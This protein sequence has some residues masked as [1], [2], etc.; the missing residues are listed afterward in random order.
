MTQWTK[1][2]R[3]TAPRVPPAE[4]F[5]ATHARVRAARAYIF[6]IMPGVLALVTLL[7]VAQ[8]LINPDDVPGGVWIA[9]GAFWF[10]QLVWIALVK[11]GVSAMLVAGLSF[12]ADGLIEFGAMFSSAEPV[13]ASASLTFFIV[14]SS[15][16]LPAWATVAYATTCAVGISLA[17]PNIERWGEAYAIPSTAF[18]ALITGALCAFVMS[19]VRMTEQRLERVAAEQVA[20]RERLE[21][22]DRARDR[23]IANVSHEL[24]T[25]LTSTIGSIETLMRE[26]LEID[27]G[28]R[29]QLM[30]VARDGGHRLLACPRRPNDWARSLAMQSSGST[31]AWDAR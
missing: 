24:R 20:A 8:W 21:Q 7:T 13:G 27:E 23:L 26:D 3:R 9:F 31:R 19:R 29:A 2:E 18:V 4:A 5:S 14:A 12:V 22:V 15:F 28:Q 6:W 16:F 10:M 11:H 1:H 30:H 25:P 17:A